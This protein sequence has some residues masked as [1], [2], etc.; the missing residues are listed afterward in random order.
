M[1]RRR[2]HR[3]VVSAASLTS[4]EPGG[5]QE[6]SAPPA[7]EAVQEVAAPHAGGQV[8]DDGDLVACDTRAHSF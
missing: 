2:R 3:G 6:F 8:I 1:R 4:L 5:V 7:L